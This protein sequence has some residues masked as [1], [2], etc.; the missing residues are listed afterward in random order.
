MAFYTFKQNNS[1]G[2]FDVD[3]NVCH[4]VIIEALNMEHACARAE[5]I[6]IYFN[7]VEDGMDCSCCGD[8]WSVP[9]D[10]GSDTPMIYGE[11]ASE[12][13][14]SWTTPSVIIHYADG[15]KESF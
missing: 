9:W 13:K 7:G 15:R 12:Y 4:A 3:E 6:G 1:G 8:R 10:E 5:N 2:S 14:S 11:P